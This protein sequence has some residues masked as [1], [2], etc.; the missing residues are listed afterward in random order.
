MTDLIELLTRCEA[1]LRSV[2]EGFWADKIK[3][4]LARANGPAGNNALEGA[5]AWYGGMGSFN[6]LIISDIND[7]EL[8]GRSEAVLNY[9]FE[10]LRQ[11]INGSRQKVE[12][13]ENQISSRLVKLCRLSY[14]KNLAQQ[15][16]YQT[17]GSAALLHLYC[18]K[19]L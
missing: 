12:N 9:E 16:I 15:D 5:L 7:H 19:W 11:S 17:D 10:R 1:L 2:E 8:K 14:N 18:R 13:N 6:D 3:S 4:I